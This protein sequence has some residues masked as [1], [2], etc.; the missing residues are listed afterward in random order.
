MKTDRVTEIKA[1]DGT[2]GQVQ[3]HWNLTWFFVVV[4]LYSMKVQHECH[5]GNYSWIFSL[6]L[7]MHSKWAIEWRP[8]KSHWWTSQACYCWAALVMFKRSNSPSMLAFMSTFLDF[9]QCQASACI[10]VHLYTASIRHFNYTNNIHLSYNK[11]SFF[12]SFSKTNYN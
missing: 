4:Y 7:F 2:S 10:W 11:L 6:P 1:K 5:M 3:T 8:P 9:T 12:S